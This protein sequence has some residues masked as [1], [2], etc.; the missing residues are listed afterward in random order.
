MVGQ[1][2]DG[3]G[4]SDPANIHTA[5]NNHTATMRTA[6]AVASAL[7]LLAGAESHGGLTT[8]LPRNSFNQPLTP[9]FP[10]KFGGMT[11]Y[12]DDGCVPGCDSC[13]HH[14]AT[15]AYPSGEDGCQL[16]PGGCFFGEENTTNMWAAPS[17]VRC[18]VDG[19]PVR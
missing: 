8:P 10:A 14:G 5:A 2:A 17:N 4:T 19:K 9:G 6:A 11:N 16:L 18:T 3:R 13:L 7:A 15:G 12:Y 1:V